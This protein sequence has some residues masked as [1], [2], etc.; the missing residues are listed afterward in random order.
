MGLEK[1]DGYYL[2]KIQQSTAFRTD[3][4]DHVYSHLTRLSDGVT[5]MNVD[6]SGTAQNF[7]YKV[8][9][10]TVYKR[11]LFSRLN[12]GIVDGGIGWGEFAGLGALL[13]NGLLL[14]I[15]DDQS[16]VLQDF[17]TTA[18]PIKANENF[19]DLAGADAIAVPAAGDDA[20][21]VRFSIFKSGNMMTLLPNYSVRLV[22]QDDLTDLSH[23][24][25][26]VQ[27]ILRK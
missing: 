18:D 2:K 6:G 8:P 10:G 13:T 12:I 20:F 24:H 3:P 22:V 16:V 19:I 25:A 21:P 11:F 4:Q 27:G 9:A 17:G 15:L 14:Q 1:S 5:E 7:D 26:M 23:F